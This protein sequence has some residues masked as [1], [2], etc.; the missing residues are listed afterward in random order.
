MDETSPGQT[1]ATVIATAKIDGPEA[2]GRARFWR[3]SEGA[4]LLT[5]EDYWVA[6]APDPRL[7][8]T[9]RDDD[10]LE[11]D[12]AIHL[13]LVPTDTNHH[14]CTLPASTDLASVRSIL[15]YCLKYDVFFGSG[16]VQRP[17]E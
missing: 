9:R 1:G 3:G 17:S 11:L 12:T 8:L 16:R 6:P 7:Y 15:V 5:L 13:G 14:Q 10:V 2:R 4:L